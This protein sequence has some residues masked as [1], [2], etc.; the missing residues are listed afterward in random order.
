MK[1]NQRIWL[2]RAGIDPPTPSYPTQYDCS[3][4]P[5]A[6]P[7]KTGP[8]STEEAQ[9]QQAFMINMK[10]NQL[11]SDQATPIFLSLE[12]FGEQRSL[13]IAFLKTFDHNHY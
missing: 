4:L 10:Q 8:Y 2:A 3:W 13:L 11:Q 6:A 9:Q 12:P 7:H 1:K 5:S